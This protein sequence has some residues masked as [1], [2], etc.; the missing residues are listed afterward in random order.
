MIK[1]NIAYQ[2]DELAK[3][4]SSNR[5]RFDDFYLSERQMIEKLKPN[6]FSKVL[7]I[8]CGCGGLGKALFER[9][10]V[11]CYTGIDINLQAINLAQTICKHG[12]FFQ[13]DFAEI[14]LPQ[15]NQV[16]NLIFSLSAIDYNIRFDD[17]LK[18][19]WSLLEPGGNLVLSLRLSNEVPF[20]L[21][22]EESW[23]Y[24]NS[25]QM[26]EGEQAPYLVFN[27]LFLK[28]KLD[29]LMPLQVMLNGYYGKPSITAITRLS[30]VFFC[31]LAIQKSS[32]ASDHQI[33]YTMISK[34]IPTDIA[35]HFVKDT[36]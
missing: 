16:F 4:F 9:F 28:E 36:T 33:N 13:G 29:N 34:K 30:K 20:Y 10:G 6:N 17:M 23:Q 19:A 8:G 7:D 11:A 35:N 12:I 5:I 31:V 3:I 24:I 15:S 27:P 32:S 2:S 22:V 21:G 1:K 26:K 14:L 25:R 18:K